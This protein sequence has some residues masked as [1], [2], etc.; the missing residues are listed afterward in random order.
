MKYCNAVFL[1]GI[2]KLKWLSRMKVQNMNE[3]KVKFS[4]VF[5]G[6]NARVFTFRWIKGASRVK[7][8]G[9]KEIMFGCN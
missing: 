2:R 3:F 5:L 7:A 8:V 9:L 4:E 6:K 1:E